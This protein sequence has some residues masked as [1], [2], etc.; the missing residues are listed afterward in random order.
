M[1][2]SDPATPREIRHAPGAGSL[3]AMI[4]PEWPAS[5]AAMLAINHRLGF[6]LGFMATAWQG[7]VESVLRAT[8]RSAG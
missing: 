5:N 2:R 3:A 8:A 4:Q 1:R 6:T 7:P